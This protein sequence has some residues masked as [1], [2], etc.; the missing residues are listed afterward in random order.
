MVA[1][2]VTN[3]G[4]TIKRQSTR[5]TV[6]NP[7]ST[8]SDA[9]TPAAQQQQSLDTSNVGLANQNANAFG[10]RS[11]SFIDGNG[12]LREIGKVIKLRAF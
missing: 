4:T 12:K 9:G 7:G 11:L 3:I 5:T 2:A 1:P 6:T 8:V 10:S